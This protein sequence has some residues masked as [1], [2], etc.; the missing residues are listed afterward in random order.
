MV[1]CGDDIE[2]FYCHAIHRYPLLY[3]LVRG[4][5]TRTRVPLA[6]LLHSTLQYA[7]TDPNYTVITTYIDPEILDKNITFFSILQLRKISN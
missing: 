2:N 6:A 5:E 1:R 4:D 3:L 7:F